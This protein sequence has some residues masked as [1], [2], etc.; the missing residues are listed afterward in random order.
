MAL[1]ACA[2]HFSCC[3]C[4]QS[5]KGWV[6][7]GRLGCFPFGCS[8]FFPPHFTGVFLL[9]LYYKLLTSSKHRQWGSLQ[10]DCVKQ[11]KETI[12]YS[13]GKWLKTV[14]ISEAAMPGLDIVLAW[15]LDKYAPWG[16]KRSKQ[17]KRRN[18]P[19]SMSFRRWNHSLHFFSCVVFCCSCCC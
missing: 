8:R 5:G 19:L 16:K 17:E 15:F 13:L 3:C 4:F 10:A 7:V 11:E 12:T 2:L 9:G 18:T 6:R 14:I 1:S